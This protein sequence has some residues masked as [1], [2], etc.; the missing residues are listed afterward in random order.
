MIITLQLRLIFVLGSHTCL[1]AGFPLHNRQ[2]SPASNPFQT[3]LSGAY[4]KFLQSKGIATTAF[5]ALPAE[6]ITFTGE[7]NSSLLETN[8]AIYNA[9]DRVRG[10]TSFS[11]EHLHFAMN[12]ACA[13]TNTSEG[14]HLGGLTS[15]MTSACQSAGTLK[16]SAAQQACT[17]SQKALEAGDKSNGDN[18]GV[19]NTT[20]FFLS[21]LPIWVNVS[22]LAL[23]PPGVYLMPAPKGV[24]LPYYDLPSLN[25][26][27]LPW[28]SGAADGPPALSWNSTLDASAVSRRNEPIVQLRPSSMSVSFGGID[29]LDVAR[30]AWFDNFTGAHAVENPPANDPDASLHP[31]PKGAATYTDKVIVVYKPKVVLKF[32]SQVVL[33]MFTPSAPSGGVWGDG[34]ASDIDFE[35]VYEPQTQDAFIVGT[36]LRSYW[37]SNSTTTT[38]ASSSTTNS[39]AASSSLSS[40]STVVASTTS[41]VASDSTAAASSSPSS[42][43][44]VANPT[45]AAASSYT[46]TTSD[47]AT[48][49]NSTDSTTSASSSSPTSSADSSSTTSSAYFECFRII[50][51]SS[52]SVS[53]SRR[54]IDRGRSM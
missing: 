43:S 26:T 12:L 7:G 47:T 16:T 35:Y 11:R 42:N 18:E 48:S 25:L 29:L 40:N 44:T 17:A 53:L 51:M 31:S 33:D 30:G 6:K 49:S 2:I 14:G 23:S 22:D 36:V 13:K 1:T 8:Q 24:V 50:S 54:L 46:A 4:H 21:V 27:L 9:V 37:D 34:V 15:R 45:S 52:I 10:N 28:Q 39:A 38:N 3:A 32:Q 41:A 19:L 5:Y 20:Q